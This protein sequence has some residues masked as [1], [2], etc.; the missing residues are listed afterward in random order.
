MSI[1]LATRFSGSLVFAACLIF[2][3]MRL[4]TAGL[5]GEESWREV[6]QDGRYVL[7]M[8]SP[9]ITEANR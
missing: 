4:A 1:Q 8:I 9:D 3:P 6:S 5:M 7:V 2:A